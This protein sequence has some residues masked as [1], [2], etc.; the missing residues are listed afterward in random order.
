MVEVKG[1]WLTVR[2]FALPSAAELNQALV[3]TGPG[4]A[5]LP[6]TTATPNT[7]VVT[8]VAI[9]PLSLV[10]PLLW[11]PFL[12]PVNVWNLTLKRTESMVLKVR[13]APLL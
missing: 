10:H 9:A 11:S 7:L 8:T 3:N 4:A 6:D 2:D 13:T 12:T 1:E 5:R